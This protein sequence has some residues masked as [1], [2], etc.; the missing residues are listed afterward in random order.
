MYLELIKSNVIMEWIKNILANNKIN[1]NVYHLSTNSFTVLK[2]IFL[3]EKKSKK[4]Q[5]NLHPEVSRF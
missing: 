2:P 3:H 5:R 1:G 4:F